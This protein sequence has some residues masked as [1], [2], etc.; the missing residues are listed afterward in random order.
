M[1]EL[2][3]ASSLMDL[4]LEKAAENKASQITT[5]KIKIGKLS[6][7]EPHYLKEAFEVVKAG[8]IAENCV[9]ECFLQDVIIFCEECQ[10]ESVLKENIFTCPV[11][12]TRDIKVID[13]EDLF[14]MAIELEK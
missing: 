14:L 9:L 4:C 11:C 2:S 6:G 7:V 1:H 3:I 8:S 5:I 12:Q 13:G 10:K